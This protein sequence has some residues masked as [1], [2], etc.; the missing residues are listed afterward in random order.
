LGLD[1]DETRSSFGKIA[2]DQFSKALEGTFPSWLGEDPRLRLEYLKTFKGT[3]ETALVTKTERRIVE[4]ED[5]RGRSDDDIRHK[6]RYGKWPE[7]M[8][9]SGDD[10]SAVN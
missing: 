7:E 10:S 4:N 1:E 2:V 9:I 3:L 6:L 5:T 8:V